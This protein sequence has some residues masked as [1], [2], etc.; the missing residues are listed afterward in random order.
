[1]TKRIILVAAMVALALG[2]WVAVPRAHRLAHDVKVALAQTL[3]GAAA[4]SSTIAVPRVAADSGAVIVVDPATVQHTIPADF[5]GIN[6][7]AFW[8]AGQGS[9]ASARAL[10]QTPIRTIRFPGG[11]PAD[12]YDWQQPLYKGWSSTSPLA[13]WRYTRSAGATS[14][15][16]GTNYQGHLPNPPGKSYSVNSPANAAAWVAY[17]RAHGINAV[18]EVGNEEDLPLMHHTDDPA[19][20]PYINAFNAQALAMHAADPH[21][22]V[23][24]PVETN[25][26]YWWG[27]DGLG[28]FLRGA[29]NRTGSGQVDGVSLHFYKGNSWYDSRGVAQYWLSPSGPWA[30]IQRMIRDHDTRNLPVYLTEWNLGS[31]D[32][33]NA[34]TPTLGHALAVADVLGAFA[35]SGVAGED[36]FDIHYANGWGLLYGSGENRPAD[37]PTP[38]YYAMALW[39][40]MGTR[41]VAL[42]QR[43]DPSSV[44]SAYATT[45]GRSVQT[46][47]I[48]KQHVPRTVRLSLDGATPNGHRLRVYTLQGAAGGITDLDAIYDGVRMPSPQRPLPGPTDAG[49]VHG[50][51]IV[52]RIPAYSAVVLDLDG[53]SPAPRLAHLP[54]SAPLTAQGPALHVTARGSV[55]YPTLKGGEV[56]PLHA[57]VE[58]NDDMGTTLIDFEVYDAANRKVFQTTRNVDLSA[59]TP[60]AVTE[61]YTLPANASGGIYTFKL[62]VFGPNWNPSY[63][64]VAAARFQVS[65]PP[66]AQITATGSVSPATVPRGATA[67]FTAIVLAGG[68]SLSQ[69]L[70]DIEVYSSSGARLCQRVTNDVTIPKDGSVRITAHC[71]IPSDQATGAYVEKIGVFGANWSPLYVWNDNAASFVVGM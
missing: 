24:G 19:F 49:I 47:V 20:Q 68:N 12:W 14:V 37:S 21:V 18:M 42:S 66:P 61:P 27:L 31:S 70:V 17:D 6:Y 59:N 34:F 57:L 26:Y 41:L 51:T 1:M 43:D 8:D 28:M 23:L 39:G 15:V 58:S 16:F 22:R 52:Y 44:L 64:W 9:A 40:H 35:Q 45:R 67:T 54:S 33:N 48:N 60:V 25:E 7:V 63:A 36:Y 71:A 50:D 30:A 4:G 46:L 62:G 5:F 55:G 65:G 32:S 11:A 56:Q 29:G 69:A 10:G 2:G 13:L 38:T 53:T 3:H